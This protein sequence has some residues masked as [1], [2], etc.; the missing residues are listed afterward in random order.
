MA[1]KTRKSNSKTRKFKGDNRAAMARGDK[2]KTTKLENMMADSGTMSHMTA[3]S[4]R[5][6]DQHEFSM[7]IRL[8]EDSTTTAHRVGL[9]TVN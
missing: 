8:A 6:T 3:E 7:T 4:A 5:V 1:P 2:L 9:R